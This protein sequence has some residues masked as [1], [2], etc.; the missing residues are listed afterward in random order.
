MEEVSHNLK[1]ICSHSKN[2]NTGQSLHTSW[3]QP[4]STLSLCYISDENSEK[5]PQL[6]PLT[7]NRRTVRRYKKSLGCRTVRRY[8]KVFSKYSHKN[9]FWPSASKTLNPRLAGCRDSARLASKMDFWQ[10]FE[11]FFFFFFPNGYAPNFQNFMCQFVV[12]FSLVCCNRFISLIYQNVR[13][14]V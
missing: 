5:V 11:F 13:N 9:I 2:G 6:N 10:I 14:L 8:K 1:I 4:S 3:R 7:Q 12:I